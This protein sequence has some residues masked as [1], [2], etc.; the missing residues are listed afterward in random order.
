MAKR[1]RVAEAV[2]SAA[3]PPFWQKK[4]ASCPSMIV[5][6]VHSV[7][8]RHVVTGPGLS[9]VICP[10]SESAFDMVSFLDI[11]NCRK[12]ALVPAFVPDLAALSSMVMPTRLTTPLPYQKSPGTISFI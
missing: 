3:A 7:P 12:L 4:Q 6:H 5:P 8:N 1:L 9:N 11:V 10:F 2:C